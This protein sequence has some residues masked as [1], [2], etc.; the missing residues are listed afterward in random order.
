M[1]NSVSSS[2]ALSATITSYAN[3]TWESSR[4]RA[5]RQS[6]R[7]SG[8]LYPFTAI[9]ISGSEESFVMK[10]LATA[11]VMVMSGIEIGFGRNYPHAGAGYIQPMGNFSLDGRGAPLLLYQA[12][13]IEE[14]HHQA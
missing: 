5:V 11:V 14:Q 6:R 10:L 8:F 12:P 9:V 1:I 2:V 7:S 4:Y 13:S 3:E